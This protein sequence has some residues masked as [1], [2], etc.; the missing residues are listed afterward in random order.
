M[1]KVME[2]L[3]KGI[4][5]KVIAEDIGISRNTLSANIKEAEKFGYGAFCPRFFAQKLRVNCKGKTLRQAF[6]YYKNLT[7]TRMNINTFRKWLFTL[8][9][10][11]LKLGASHDRV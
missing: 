1:A 5:L 10:D 9:V 6:R 11:Y 7:G 4:T 2:S 8:K 3:H